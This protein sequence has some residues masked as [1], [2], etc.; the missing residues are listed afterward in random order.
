MTVA[1]VASALLEPETAPRAVAATRMERSDGVCALTLGPLNGRTR[2][3]DLYQSSP[4]RALMPQVDDDEIFSAVM[5]T[6]SGGLAGGD[7]IRVSVTAEPGARAVVTSQASEKIYRS[8]GEDTRVSLTLSA[9]ADT[10]LEW[11]PQGAI[12]FDNSR[13]VRRNVIDA[14]PAARVLAGEIVVFGRTASGEVFHNGL[15]HDAWQ[16]R[17]GAKL[18][19]ADAIRLERDIDAVLAHPAGFGGAVAVATVLFVARDA[20]QRVDLARSLL[21]AECGKPGVVCG[22]SGATV[23]N[24]VLVVRFLNSDAQALMGEVASFWRGFRAA[25]AGLPARMPRAWQY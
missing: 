6:T 3:V 21:G 22:K 13:L 20:P 23:V 1:A 10:W 15:F 25:V 16:V 24:G 11:I 17:V 18:V 7:R 9:A 12:L 8:L 4:C 14:D 2:I 5:V 19:W